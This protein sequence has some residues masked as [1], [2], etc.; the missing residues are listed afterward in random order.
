M[1]VLGAQSLAGPAIAGYEPSDVTKVVL[2]GTGN[3]NTDPARSGP[4]TAIIV[5]DTPYII[6]FGPGI[7]RRASA[8]RRKFGLDALGEEN[9]GIAFATH[10]HSDH[11][12]GL[13]D[14]IFTTWVQ[15]RTIPLE[16]YGPKG[17]TAMAG[18]VLAAWAE[19]IRIRVEG[20]EPRDD[21][22]WRV[23][24]HD[25]EPGMVFR[26]DNVTVE[27]FRVCHGG[28]TDSF[29]YKFTTPD[30]VI[31]ISGDTTFCPILIEKARGADILLHEAYNVEG[32][33]KRTPEWKT[34]HAAFHTSSHDLAR[35]VGEA[36]PGLLILYHQLFMDGFTE[37]DL[38]KEVTD[39]YDGPVVS[40]KDLEVY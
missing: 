9:L 13:P 37:A 26:D 23:N 14:L 31:V 15:D 36:R 11:T 38:L 35:L 16:L 6:D 7:V 34:Y 21:T 39:H 22:G 19:D 29:G 4:S 27:A 10:L 5:R 25:I 32:W 24:A 30:R 3:P 17:T 20:L 12:V 2:L 18:H 28:I 8:A 40:G 1:L 33:N